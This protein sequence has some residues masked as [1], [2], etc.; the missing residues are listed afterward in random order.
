MAGALEG[1]RVLD[2]SQIIAGPMAASLLSEMGADVVKVEPLEG[3]P[4]RLQAE[5]IPKESRT[6][7]GQNRGK[8]GVAIDFKNPATKEAREALIRWADVLITNYRPGAAEHLGLDYPTVRA[9][10]PAIIYC[11][12]T[13]WGH[14][15]PDA[16]RRGYDSIAQAMSG[17]MTAIGIFRNGKPE[18]TGL[19]PADV[20]TGAAMAFGVAAALFHRERTGEGQMIS[21][22]LLLSALYM[23]PSFREITALDDELRAQKL[24][25]L[26]EARARG[27]TIEEIYNERMAAMPEWA[28]NVYYRGYQTAD[29]YVMVGCLGPG[30]RARFRKATGIRDPRYEEGF[31]ATPENVARVGAELVA[32]C[33]ALFR[34]KTTAEWLKILDANDIAAGPVRFIEELWDDPQVRANGYV[35][36]YDH[37]LLGPMRGAAPLVTMSGTPTRVQRSSPVLG[38]DNDEV[39]HEAGLDQ[40]QIDALREGGAI[41]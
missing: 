15:G 6:F 40:Q 12:N 24:Q 5:I 31:E 4:W 16:L 26:A 20:L 33:E 3:E 13:A 9:V 8:R 22:S 23:Q 28:G 11:D 14:E 36:E 30:P 19:A 39:L 7:I 37:P 27:A 18:A 32:E 10:N 21:T 41:L 17:L 38:G 35:V 2:C 29:G 34:S 25:R 1:V